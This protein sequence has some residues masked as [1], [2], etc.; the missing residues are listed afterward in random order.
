MLI[1]YLKK[2]TIAKSLCL[3]YII[4]VFDSLNSHLFNNTSAYILKPGSSKIFLLFFKPPFFIVIMP[5]FLL[6]SLT[7]H[8][9]TFIYIIGIGSDAYYEPYL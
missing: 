5:V 8:N 3:I 4:L 7:S 9:K 1:V 6:F 2:N